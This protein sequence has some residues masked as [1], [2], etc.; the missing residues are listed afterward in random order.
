MRPFSSACLVLMLCLPACGSDD[1]GGGGSGGSGTGGASGSGGSGA[2]GG[3]AGSGGAS[4][5]SAGTGGSGT[6]GSGTGGSGTG[7][8]GTGGTGGTSSGGIQIKGTVDGKAVNWSCAKSSLTTI[9]WPGFGTIGCA[10]STGVQADQYNVTVWLADMTAVSTL[11]AVKASAPNVGTIKGAGAM[12]DCTTGSV[13]I[14]SWDATAKRTVGSFKA[15]WT[16]VV[17]DGNKAVHLEG[18]WDLTQ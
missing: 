1:D 13:T 11:S 16:A 10:M 5:G 15:D 18:T 14:T 3:A 6:G 7:G 8:S 9:G 2:T 4:G 17:S 12:Q